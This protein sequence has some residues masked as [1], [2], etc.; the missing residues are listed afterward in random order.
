VRHDL[1]P[2]ADQRQEGEEN[3]NGATAQE[4]HGRNM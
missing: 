2:K 1:I 4:G 3:G